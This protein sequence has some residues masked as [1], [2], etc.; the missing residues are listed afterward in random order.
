MIQIVINLVKG[1]LN[2]IDNLFNKT[3][4]IKITSLMQIKS[5]VLP[6]KKESKD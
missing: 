2:S 6:R 3:K 4:T 1:K 5:K